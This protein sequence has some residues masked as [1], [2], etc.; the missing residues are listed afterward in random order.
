MVM[1]KRDVSPHEK[2]LESTEMAGR[3]DG[4][5]GKGDGLARSDRQEDTTRVFRERDRKNNIG[6]ICPQSHW[7]RSRS[8]TGR[9]VGGT[10]QKSRKQ[11][12]LVDSVPSFPSAPIVE[13]E[14]PTISEVKGGLRVEKVVLTQTQRRVDLQSGVNIKGKWVYNNLAL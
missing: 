11:A 5:R 10:G 8:W 3:I 1:S 7:E 14:R 13:S 4:G 2:G 6:K 9:R 12:F